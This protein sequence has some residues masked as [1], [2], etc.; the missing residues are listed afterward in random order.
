MISAAEFC[1]ELDGR[2]FTVASGVPCSF[3][4]GPI[5]LL[6]ARPGRYLPAANEG[7]ALAIA[8]GAALAGGRP[9][10]MLQNSG[11]GNLINPLTSLTWTYR[12]PVL[13][14]VS[15][16]G[17]PDP[18]Q[19]EPQ[20]ELMGQSTHA[21]LDTL[22]I[23]HR[24]LGA[25]A[26]LPGLRAVLDAAEAELAAGKPAFVLVE[27]GAV[28]SVRSAAEP[29]H[30]ALVS[31]DVLRMVTRAAGEDG[32]IVASTGYTARELFAV[33]DRP[34]N[35]YM[36]GSMGHASAIG[37]GLAQADRSRPVIVLDGD[38]SAL[39]HLG[40]FSVIGHQAPSNLVHIVL[41]NGMHESTG[42]QGSTSATT[43][44]S[45]VAAA[46][47]YRTAVTCR[48]AGDLELFLRMALSSPGPHLAEVS[49]RPRS[50]QAPPRATSS[51]SPISL[52]ARFAHTAQR[53]ERPV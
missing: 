2:G 38:G 41:D 43:T 1:A 42:G 27:K 6:S 10:V 34:G 14:F 33:A 16:R 3:F 32:L 45:G 36:Q 7:G 15:L 22:G 35:F 24:T 13:A 9:Y 29:D 40:N 26:E 23:A 5:T 18:A 25:G 50:G 53:K 31:A 52:A 11:L 37:L 21:L 20:H 39:M 19:D 47:G 49:T 51:A 8:A 44:F 46:T 48:T 4:S 28:G 30:E 17:W 12:I